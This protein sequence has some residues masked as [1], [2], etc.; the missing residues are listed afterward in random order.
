[1]AGGPQLDGNFNHVQI[2]PNAGVGDTAL[3]VSNGK[4][5]L[6]GGLVATDNNGNL[7]STSLNPSQTTGVVQTLTNGSTINTANIGV[8]RVTAG[9][10]VTGIILQAGT[11]PGQHVDIVHEGAAANTIT[12]A[13]SGTS[14]VADGTSDVITGPAAHTFVW[15]SITSLWY[16]C[17]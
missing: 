13:A 15:D 17:N 3:T 16:H 6:D 11:R 5:S 1:M 8:V 12:F 2:S 9:A 4:T 10:A 7:T 14:N